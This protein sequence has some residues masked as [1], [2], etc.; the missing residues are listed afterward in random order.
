MKL[1]SSVFKATSDSSLM[2]LPLPIVSILHTDSTDSAEWII[3]S[4]VRNIYKRFTSHDG[5][6]IFDSAL[7]LHM[8]PYHSSAT[9]TTQLLVTHLLAQRAASVATLTRLSVSCHKD[10]LWLRLIGSE[11]LLDTIRSILISKSCLVLHQT[12]CVVDEICWPS[13]W[14]LL[15]ISWY[16]ICT[17][18]L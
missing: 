16:I 1:P 15:I 4:P 18:M 10:K 5:S 8:V 14:L 2:P 17:L 13:L 6:R 3:T 12:Y 9:N 11:D 7:A